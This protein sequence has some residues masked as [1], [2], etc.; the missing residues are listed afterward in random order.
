MNITEKENIRCF[1]AH[2]TPDHFP[3]LSKGLYTHH[4]ILGFAER[5][6]LDGTTDWFGVQY[7]YDELIGTYSVPRAP[8]VLTDITKWREQVKIPD[9]EHMDWEKAARLDFIS[10]E[11]RENMLV[12]ILIQCGIYERYHSLMGMEEAMIA[13]LDEPEDAKDLIDAIGDY[14]YKLIEKVIMYY[15]PDIIRQHDDYGTQQA[16]QMQPDLWRRLIK[17]HTKRIVELCHSKGVFYEQHS[18]GIIEPIIYDFV[19]IGVDSWQG[20]HINNVPELRKHTGN[21]LNYHMSLNIPDY[22]V[23]DAAGWLTE[24]QLREDVRNTLLSCAGNGCY[25]TVPASVIGNVNWW[26]TSV[27]NEEIDNFRREYRY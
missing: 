15:K 26:G 12:S 14:K 17:P 23:A 25:F 20:M 11:I 13:L 24:A 7:S 21:R 2:K 16:M 1:Y 5:P 4:P 18:C 10:D 9:V 27:I 19:E 6:I 8:Y 22:Q 3:D